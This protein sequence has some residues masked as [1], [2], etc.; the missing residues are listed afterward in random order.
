MTAEH[1]EDA[2]KGGGGLCQEKSKWRHWEGG[3]LGITTLVAARRHIRRGA[4]NYFLY[5]WPWTR[6]WESDWFGF[7]SS[8]APQCPMWQMVRSLPPLLILQFLICKVRK[9]RGS[10]SWVIG[11]KWN[12][13]WTVLRTMSNS[14]NKHLINSSICWLKVPQFTF[15]TMCKGKH[16]FHLSENQSQVLGKPKLAVS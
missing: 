5:W 11:L 15:Q 2:W 6:T 7:S 12:N 9:I 13:T 14:I 1:N 3:T 16:L 10:T 8:F 4:E